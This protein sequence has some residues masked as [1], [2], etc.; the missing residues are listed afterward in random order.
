MLV[1]SLSI[2]Q[3]LRSLEVVLEFIFGTITIVVKKGSVVFH[4]DQRCASRNVKIRELSCMSI[5]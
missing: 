2:F 1:I 5:Q 4:W 3:C